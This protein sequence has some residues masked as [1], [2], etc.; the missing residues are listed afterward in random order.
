MTQPLVHAEGLLLRRTFENVLLLV[1]GSSQVLNLSGTALALWECFAS[2]STPREAAAR[3]AAG[4]GRDALTLVP[5]VVAV[6]QDLEA[7]GALVPA[8]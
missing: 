6:A 3:L 8:P 7:R 4:Y 1:P 2:A 5:D